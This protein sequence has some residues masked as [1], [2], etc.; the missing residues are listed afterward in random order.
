MTENDRVRPRSCGNNSIK[1]PLSMRS[2]T[3]KSYEL[4]DGKVYQTGFYLN[5]LMQPVKML[6]DAGHE[7]TFATP[8]GK[9]PILDQNSIDAMYFN[10]S[11]AALKEH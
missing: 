9:A 6:L 3:M 10:G 4:K 7:V 5:E 11:V 8:E 2:R 1:R